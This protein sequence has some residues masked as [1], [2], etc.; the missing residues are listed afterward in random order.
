MP[1]VL[2]EVNFLSNPALEAQTR[3]PDYAA[4]AAR[5]ILQGLLEFFTRI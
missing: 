5:G 4:K 1:A 2:V 3:Q